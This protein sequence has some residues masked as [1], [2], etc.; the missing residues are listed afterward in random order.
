[1]GRVETETMPCLD[2]AFSL[3]GDAIP[4]DHAEVLFTAL[5]GQIP[6]L[7]DDAAI[8]IHAIR[9][10]LDRTRRLHL[11]R[12]SELVLRL[13]AESIPTFLPLAGKSL[14]LGDSTVRV[15]IPTPRLLE[16]ASRLFSRLVIIKGFVDPEPFLEAAKRQLTQMEVAG[17]AVLV[18]NPHAA[19]NA[20]GT[21]GT[22]SPW[23]RRTV[24]IHG[25]RVVGFALRIEGL[26]D[27]DSIKLQEQGLGGRRHY[28]CGIV[29]PEA[30][31]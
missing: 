12:H 23:L 29:T 24:E 25:K 15:G 5:C 13:P 8:G 6:P 7:H 31:A 21:Q 4:A 10:S 17:T 16:P 30:R 2:L 22:K 1:M 9:G 3:S 28:G 14:R 20:G 11:K 26:K 27:E 19:A 18:P